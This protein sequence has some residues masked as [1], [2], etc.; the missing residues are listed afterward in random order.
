MA[1]A[2]GCD[3]AYK[4]IDIYGRK[5]YVA[6]S[7]VICK[8]CDCRAASK[9]FNLAKGYKL[10]LSLFISFL[11]EVDGQCN[12]WCN[13]ATLATLGTKRD[14]SLAV[15]VRY[16]YGK[17]SS[18]IFRD[19]EWTTCTRKDPRIIAPRGRPFYLAHS[20]YQYYHCTDRTLVY[21][22]FMYTYV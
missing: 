6:L 3:P 12:G 20:H 16:T 18:V 2:R 15:C 11:K 14:A 13:F 21:D 4:P 7:R 17:G 22:A 5:L 10:S 19:G 8:S 1:S 9:R